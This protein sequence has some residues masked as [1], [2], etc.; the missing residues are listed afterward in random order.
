MVSDDM[1]YANFSNYKKRLGTLLVLGNIKGE[2]ISG[3]RQAESRSYTR[4]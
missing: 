2:P 1:G 4:I 3:V